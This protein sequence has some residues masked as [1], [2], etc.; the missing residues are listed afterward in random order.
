MKVLLIDDEADIRSVGRL[1]LE[2]VGGWEVVDAGSGEE[3]IELARREQPDAILLDAMMPGIDG[4]ATIER[5]KAIEETSGIPVL[6]VTAKLQPADRERYLELGA[7]GVL[8]KPFDPMSLPGEVA[9]A[10][11]R[12]G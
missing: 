5:L 6:F 3:G 4:P 2:K 11:G 9:A 10:L 8:A 12:D 1:S 7:K